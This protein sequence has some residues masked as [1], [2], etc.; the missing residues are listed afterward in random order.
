MK[1]GYEDSTNDTKGIR[2]I[3]ASQD[4]RLWSP[5]RVVKRQ[6]LSLSDES[7]RKYTI[8]DY[9]WRS[10]IFTYMRDTFTKEDLI[11]TV[12]NLRLVCR[13]IHQTVI[14]SPVVWNPQFSIGNAIEYLSRAIKFGW[15][16][17]QSAL[18]LTIGCFYYDI[19]L[20][21]VCTDQSERLKEL[22]TRLNISE[23][24]LSPLEDNLY[25][26]EYDGESKGWSI[27]PFVT[28]TLR[29]LTVNALHGEHYEMVFKDLNQITLDSG[30]QLCFSLSRRF[31]MKDIDTSESNIPEYVKSVVLK[32]PS[33]VYLTKHAAN[34]FRTICLDILEQ[35]AAKQT[36]GRST[37]SSPIFTLIDNF[38]GTSL[39]L[40]T[41]DD[42][43]AFLKKWNPEKTGVVTLKD[44]SI[45]S[46]LLCE[47]CPSLKDKED[48]SLCET[49]HQKTVEIRVGEALYDC[50]EGK[51]YFAKFENTNQVVENYSKL[52]SVKSIILRHTNLYQSVL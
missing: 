45:R 46:G 27:I 28:H 33:N 48:K 10:H 13:A 25:V 40:N 22:M 15:D 20:M 23:L 4:E 41:I 9:I 5:P 35:A 19:Y 7:G 38:K 51:T 16:L 42:W 49:E 36:E 43:C 30:F 17:S 37:A 32:F 26:E 14:Q 44:Q 39:T 50:Y 31:L 21:K 18:T 29:K 47:T 11:A 2:P 3:G 24:T 8:Q 12:R 1:R 6:K 34:T 52:V